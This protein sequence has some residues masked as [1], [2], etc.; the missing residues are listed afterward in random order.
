MEEPVASG[1]RRSWWK[2]LLAGVAA[3]VAA[4]IAWGSVEPEPEPEEELPPEG[5]TVPVELAPVEAGPPDA[6]VRT[7]PRWV[8]PT[9]LWTIGVVVAVVVGAVLLEAMRDVVVWIVLALFFSFALEPA[10]NYMQARFGW[11]RGVTTLLLLAFLLVAL[12][13]IGTIFLSAVIQ[14]LVA[15]ATRLPEWAQSLSEWLSS[16]FGIEIDTSS[17]PSTSEET[18]SNLLSAGASAVELL[19]G[20]TAS[21]L[22]SLLAFFTVAMFIFYMVAEAP[23]FKRAVLSFFSHER[24]EELVSIWEAAIEKTGGYFYSRLLVAMINGSLTYVVFLILGVPGAAALALFQGAVAAFIPIVGTYIAAAV[25]AVVIFMSLGL[26]ETVIYLIWVL[27]YQ[28]VENLLIYPRVQGKTMQLHP[29]IAFGA[30]L[31]GGALGGLMW[32]FLA[33]PFAATVQA[34]A[35]LWIERHEVD[36]TSFV[37]DVGRTPRHGE[38]GEETPPGRLRTAV[39]RSRGWLRRRVKEPEGGVVETP[40]LPVASDPGAP[41]IESPRAGDVGAARGEQPAVEGTSDAARNEGGR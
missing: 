13:L 24:Q 16:T 1:P 39:R 40:E 38:D 5:A 20:I 36:E 30:A 32:A 23:K 37:A 26:T 28:Q 10:V 15:I 2:W 19:F 4:A 12:V 31:A 6:G 22:T 21:L 34:S 27:I 29:A 41:V 11:R 18:V 7:P 33:L 35:S 14:G 3:L 25:P 9:V 8:K 17:V